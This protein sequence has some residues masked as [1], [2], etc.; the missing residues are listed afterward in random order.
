M[1]RCGDGVCGPGEALPS[2]PLQLLC[3][4]AGVAGDQ[5]PAPCPA[6]CGPPVAACPRPLLDQVGDPAQVRACSAVCLSHEQPGPLS[7][8]ASHIQASLCSPRLTD[9]ALP[10]AV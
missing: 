1:N 6:D 2:G 8:L 5:C 7:V 9:P 10:G 4:R 3:Q